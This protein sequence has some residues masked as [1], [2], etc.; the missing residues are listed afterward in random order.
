M[1]SGHQTLLTQHQVP[2]GQRQQ[3][4]ITSPGG[5]TLLSYLYASATGGLGTNQALL[6]PAGEGHPAYPVIHQYYN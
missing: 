4:G 2:T 5:E 1:S 3:F 6:Q